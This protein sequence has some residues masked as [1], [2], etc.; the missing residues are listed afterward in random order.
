M[1]LSTGAYRVPPPCDESEI[2]H[3]L[4]PDVQGTDV[5]EVAFWLFYVHVCLNSSHRSFSRNSDYLHSAAGAVASGEDTFNVGSLSSVNFDAAPLV[6]SDSR[7][8]N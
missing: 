8:Y 3:H 7:L 5:E 4:N 6:N 2:H 1:L